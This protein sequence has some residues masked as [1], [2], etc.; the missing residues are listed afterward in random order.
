MKFYHVTLVDEP[1]L[2]SIISITITC[3]VLL[4]AYGLGSVPPRLLRWHDSSA[5]E[6]LVRL[7][8]GLAILSH[9]MLAFGLLSLYST[10]VVWTLVIIGLV[11]LWWPLFDFGRRLR[12]ALLS[13]SPYGALERVMLALLVGFLLLAWLGG[14]APPFA[15]DTLREH[16]G[17][18]KLFVTEGRIVFQ[19][20]LFYNM[21]SAV[22][23]LYVL[24]TLLYSPTV[25]L[26]LNSTFLVLTTLGIYH[27]AMRHIS[28]EVGLL[29][30]VLF[31]SIPLVWYQSFQGKVDLG[32]YLYTSL[33]FFLLSE[34]RQSGITAQLVLAGAF[35]GAAMSTK[36]IGV[37]TALS[38]SGIVLFVLLRAPRDA[39][40][41]L[42]ALS[43]Y[44]GALLLFGS[45]WYL[46]NWFI[47]GNP[48]YPIFYP[49]LGGRDWNLRA[50]ELGLQDL[51]KYVILRKDWWGFLTGPIQ[52]LLGHANFYIRGELGPLFLAFLPVSFLLRETRRQHS[53]AFGFAAL[54]Y[55]WWFPF[56]QVGRFLLP[57]FTLFCIP[58]AH[59]VFLLAK[60]GRYLRNVVWGSVFLWF[61]LSGG[62][63]VQRT[64]WAVPPGLG[65]TS[66]EQFLME[67]VDLYSDIKWM[68]NNLPESAVVLTNHN[69]PYYFERKY[70]WGTVDEQ[71]F[72]D[73][74]PMKGAEDLLQRMR[75]LGVTHLFNLTRSDTWRTQQR[76]PDIL[77]Y[78][79]LY[80]ELIERYSRPLYHNPAAFLV[81]SLITGNTIPAEVFIY[82]LSHPDRLLA[83]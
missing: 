28:K 33:A 34:W 45:P 3:L 38:I 26:L 35:S 58:V 49:V 44:V 73:Y 2:E 7:A 70:I 42:K 74:R 23:M 51:E 19:P 14:L 9:V 62:A 56:A 71:G 40:S 12:E 46:K 82:E 53:L 41:K 22:E 68:N 13:V 66:R 24:G 78:Q 32:L 59:A 18:A 75:E 39:G 4:F 29:A 47:T 20:V 11:I 31:S 81:D 48:I 57:V 5:G 64:A 37:Y 83:K 52:I 43:G 50:Y 27:F 77:H 15:E 69:Q 79:Q 54:F 8:L 63:L 72:I 16:L 60:K 1:L 36:Y 30:A 17:V 61:A 10:G 25:G 80:D 55:A 67:T 6:I 65:I 21:P 76:E